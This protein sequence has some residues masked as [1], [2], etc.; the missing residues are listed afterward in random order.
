MDAAFALSGI[1][2]KVVVTSLGESASGTANGI[3]S[4][5]EVHALIIYESNIG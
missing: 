2:V 5:L 1:N 4:Y 3:L